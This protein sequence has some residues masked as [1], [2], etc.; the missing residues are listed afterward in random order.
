VKELLIIAALAL[1]MGCQPQSVDDLIWIKPQAPVEQ[2]APA[3]PA[4]SPPA[5][6]PPA[7][8]T[9]PAPEPLPP[10]VWTPEPLHVYVL[11][12]SDTILVDET[13]T[14][15]S[16][17][18]RLYMWQLTAEQQTRDFP[19]DPWHVVGGGIPAEAL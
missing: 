12:S 18:L 10:V 17:R 14:A 7:V 8:E 13:E 15:E 16:Y 19:D 6:A 5:E 9:P 1:L 3:P 4:E 2:P 11:D